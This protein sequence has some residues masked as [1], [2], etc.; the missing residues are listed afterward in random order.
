LE[1]FV[2]THNLGHIDFAAVNGWSVAQF[3][4]L[5]SKYSTQL[6]KEQYYEMSTT[7]GCDLIAR[8]PSC[9][10]SKSLGLDELLIGSV[11]A[12]FRVTK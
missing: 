2:A 10:K 12:L 7:T 3:R 8:F 1:D 4:T 9:F 6:R 5:W 11:D